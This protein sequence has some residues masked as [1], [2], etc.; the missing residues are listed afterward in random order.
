[1]LGTEAGGSA[2]GVPGK[3]PQDKA[4]SRDIWNVQEDISSQ[5][6]A[7]EPFKSIVKQPCGLP[8]YLSAVC[9][10][11]QGTWQLL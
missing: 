4:S 6:M 3:K 9:L 2:E 10:P 7:E 5:N 8:S 11:H 1:M